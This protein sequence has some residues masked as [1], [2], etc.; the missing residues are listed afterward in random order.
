M[1]LQSVEEVREEQ[2]SAR[3]QLINADMSIGQMLFN[4]HINFVFGWRNYTAQSSNIEGTF[5]P[6]SKH[7]CKQQVSI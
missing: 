3:R 1:V 7:A 4:L 6:V 2:S 5:T